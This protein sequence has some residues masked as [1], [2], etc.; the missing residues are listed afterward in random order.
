[1][2]GEGTEGEGPSL[3]LAHRKMPWIS[4]RRSGL[5]RWLAA[6]RA[7][8]IP[9]AGLALA[10]VL[11]PRARPAGPGVD[12]TEITYWTPGEAS[13]AMRVAIEVFE[14]RHPQYRVLL[15][16]ATVRSAT[17]DPTRFLLGVAGDVPPDLIFFDRF[18][19][20]EWAS[21]G[22]FEDLTPRLTAER[23]RP[24]GVRAADFFGP[25]WSEGVWSDR[26]YA[27]PNSVDTRAL[28][29]HHGAL[30]RAGLV[31]GPDDPE[32]R[33]GSATAGQPRPPRTWE[34]LCRKRVHAIGRVDARGIVRLSDWARRPA[35]NEDVG[36]DAPL[37]VQARGV[38]RGDVLV[39]VA[40]TDVFRARVA[41]VEGPVA[42]HLDLARDQPPGLD[43]VPARFV[44]ADCHVKVFDQDGYVVRLTRY[45][46][47]TGAL[48]AV[49]LV[50]LF[51][52]SWLYMYGWLNGAT[53]M[54]PDGRTCRLDSPEIVAALQFVTD[55]YD[56][57]GGVAIAGAFEV[58]AASG[59]L[60]PFLTGKIAMRID[61]D[62]FLGRISAFTPDLRFGT[63]GAPIPEARLAAGHAPVGW[64]GGW[65]YAIPST[66]RHKDAAWELLRWLCSV[67]ANKLMKAYAASSERARGRPFYPGLHPDRRVMRWLR[68]T[69]VQQN[70]TL[71]ADVRRGY[72]TFADLLPA[73][74]HRPVTPVGQF[75]WTE[76]DR[77]TNAAIRHTQPPC[78]A[79][80][81]GSRR[82]QAA[83]DRHLRPPAGPHVAWGRIVLAY[84]AGVA[85]VFLV[86]IAYQERRRRRLGLR[87]R[88]WL[89]GY[90]CAS[91]WL[92]GF[93]VFGAGPIIFS[94]VISFS[95]YDVINPA[96]FVGLANYRNLLG[97][98]HEPVV[99]RAVPNDPLLWRSLGNT[100][101][102]MLAVPLGL[103]F[104]LGLALLLNTRARGLAFF[105]TVYYLPAV[106]PAVAAFVLWIWVFDPVRGLLNQVLRGVGVDQPP[107]WLQDPAWAKPAL[108]LMGLWGAGSGMIIWLAGLREIPESLYEAARIDG[109][110]RPQMFRH[111]TLPLLTPY[112]FFNLLM[113]LIGV[114]QIFESAYVMTDGGPADATLFYAYKLFNEAFRH[115][116]MGAASAMAWI[117][118]VVVLAI[119]LV[120]L[121]LGRKWVH[122]ER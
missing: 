105:R 95:H 93:V 78:G 102:M 45:D 87:H 99:G 106:V 28:Y 69:Y 65:S 64:M 24:D 120:Q 57:I 29:Y 30:V 53:F 88:G 100:A 11:Y 34:Q 104:G 62:G 2:L 114:F 72:Q 75:L 56:A 76:S 70:P 74:K 20:V 63:V 58:G 111:V 7:W 26:V 23:D 91:P 116:N 17:A 71:S 66:A 122:Y 6:H 3:G 80:R 86:L 115:L 32:V 98:H 94:L 54:S 61:G 119:T 13:D 108:I 36:P 9:L 89:A 38:R 96:R 60:D 46:A 77:A 43:A 79:L 16:T 110:S 41:R 73:S 8:T 40:G 35:V 33:S 15:G 31:H 27:I 22:A 55:L 82:V 92:V 4:M 67:E 117:L 52:N 25:A 112:I 12:A 1:M 51:G 47:E 50:P 81:Y 14:R 18:A 59:A 48:R 19:V 49:G 101:F 42:L 44:G 90:V 103:A 5:S 97:F 107:H 68:A 21:R 85:A 118:F 84:V 10:W 113:G 121:W 83:L 39:L 109:A 37:D